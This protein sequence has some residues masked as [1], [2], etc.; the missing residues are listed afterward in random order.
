VQAL[1]DQG[2]GVIAGF[3]LGVPGDTVESLVAEYH[4]F[5]ALPLLVVSPSILGPDPGTREYSRAKSR[6]GA[7]FELIGEHGLRGD[8][9]RYGTGAPVGLPPL[10]RGATKDDLNLLLDV[11]QGHFNVSQATWT[12]FHRDL[13]ADREEDLT[14]YLLVL[15]DRALRLAHPDC[16]PAIID[17]AAEVRGRALDWLP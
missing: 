10:S 13:P 8:I 3:I 11:V 2:I 14:N 15:H 4:D 1:D 5:Q 12:R 16:H 9:A 6:G 17:L 7:F